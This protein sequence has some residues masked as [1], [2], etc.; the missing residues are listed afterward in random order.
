MKNKLR[1]ILWS[2]SCKFVYIPHLEP[3]K[4][5]M[6]SG[7]FRWGRNEGSRASWRGPDSRGEMGLA[8]IGKPLKPVFC[9]II[10]QHQ[11]AI[12]GGKGHFQTHPNGFTSRILM[13]WTFASRISTSTH[14]ISMNIRNV[15]AQRVNASSPW[16]LRTHTHIY[17]SICK[18][19]HFHQT[20]QIH[21]FHCTFLPCSNV[22]SFPLQK[23]FQ[24]RY[25]HTWARTLLSPV[26]V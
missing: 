17:I 13:S 4:K 1:Y 15:P 10:S 8:P 22:V 25:V 3:E 21:V 23:L 26:S 7:G 2:E 12:I 19:G 20:T 6:V 24:G 16:S 11:M 18:N 9:F 5:N 14:Q